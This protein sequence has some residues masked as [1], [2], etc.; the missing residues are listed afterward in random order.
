MY[1]VTGVDR[2]ME[3]RVL[4]G[5]W[6]YGCLQ[7]YGVTGVYRCMYCSVP[8]TNGEGEW[9]YEEIILDRVSLCSVVRALETVHDIERHSSTFFCM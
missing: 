8:Q 3:L 1:G 2:C 9:E 7:V 4:T 5:V 6:S